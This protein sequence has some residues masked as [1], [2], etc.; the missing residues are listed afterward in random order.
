MEDIA[1]DIYIARLDEAFQDDYFD[2]GRQ[3]ELH[4]DI[5]KRM[6]PKEQEDQIASE[7]AL[8]NAKQAVYEKLVAER[9]ER[10]KQTYIASWKTYLSERE[11]Y[12]D[13]LADM[14]SRF[15]RNRS[16]D[17]RLVASGSQRR[18]FARDMFSDA[19]YAIIDITRD[20]QGFKQATNLSP[21]DLRYDSVVSARDMQSFTFTM[22]YNEGIK[23]AGGMM[24]SESRMKVIMISSSLPADASRPIEQLEDELSGVWMRGRA[25]IDEV[26]A[27]AEGDIKAQRDLAFSVNSGLLEKSVSMQLVDNDYDELLGGQSATFMLAL[28]YALDGL[29]MDKYASLGGQN[30]AVRSEAGAGLQAGVGVGEDA[31]GDNGKYDFP[32]PF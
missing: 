22:T 27:A 2:A 31:T 1:R 20:K 17:G 19:R 13:E 6:T 25:A 3:A 14:L 30:D 9:K 8:E 10:D 7:R 29:G 21:D 11:K 12:K 24:M 18:A 28:Q 16:D 23:N 5:M 26:L 4:A 15:G 32:I